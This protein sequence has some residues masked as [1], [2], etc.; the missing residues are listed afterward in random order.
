MVV[1]GDPISSGTWRVF[2]ITAN[3]YP[4]S[5]DPLVV[6]G[7]P[8]RPGIGTMPARVVC[9]RRRRGTSDLNVEKG[10]GSLIRTD[11]HRDEGHHGQHRCTKGEYFHIKL[12]DWPQGIQ[13]QKI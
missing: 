3:P 1:A 5:I 11:K 13:L 12:L 9:A 7:D 6:A 10:R 2:I 8:D 4:A